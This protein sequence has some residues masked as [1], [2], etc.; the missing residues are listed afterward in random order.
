ML[1]RVEEV[2]VERWNH[3]Q[4]KGLWEWRL[5]WVVGNT[6]TGT[7]GCRILFWLQKKGVILRGRWEWM[8]LLGLRG[9]RTSLDEK[10]NGLK[11]EEKRRKKEEGTEWV[12]ESEWTKLRWVWR[13]VCGGLI[14]WLQVFCHISTMETIPKI[15]SEVIATWMWLLWARTSQFGVQNCWKFWQYKLITR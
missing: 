5:R 2:P 1:T 8:M 6:D 15:E 11:K 10:E 7:V 12:W 4:P 14:G 13:N 3:R 9:W